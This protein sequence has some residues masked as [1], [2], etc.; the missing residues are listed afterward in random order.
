MSHLIII[1]VQ[2]LNK[3]LEV[4]LTQID[5]FSTQNFREFILREY[6][7][8]IISR[9]KS[10]FYLSSHNLINIHIHQAQGNCTPFVSH[11]SYARNHAKI[12]RENVSKRRNFHF[13]FLKMKSTKPTRI[14]TITKP[15]K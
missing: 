5:S 6:S 3:F 9:M 8:L 15:E 4:L 12:L 7:I 14:I 13:Q 1:F 10:K 2:L 11:D